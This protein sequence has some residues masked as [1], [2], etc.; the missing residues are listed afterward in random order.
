M[1]MILIEDDVYAADDGD[2]DAVD[3][4]YVDVDHQHLQ[5]RLSLD[6]LPI[7]QNTARVLGYNIH[8]K[9]YL[10]RRCPLLIGVFLNSYLF[11]L[12]SSWSNLMGC[13]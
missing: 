3:V 8:V 12:C 4:D 2:V 5:C 7:C 11:L 9:S 13:K 6:Q 1:T 10:Y